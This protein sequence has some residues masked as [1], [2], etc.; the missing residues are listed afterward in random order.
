MRTVIICSILW[1]LLSC[2]GNTVNTG[3]NPAK[4][5][6]SD[7]DLIIKT[8]G[9]YLEYYPGKKQLKISGEFDAAGNKHGIWRFY[10]QNG[11]ETSMTTYE[12]GLREGF[13]VV[14]HPNGTLFYDGEYH[15]DTMVGAWTFYDKNGKKN[16]EIDYGLPKK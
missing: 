16:K 10:N 11:I 3:K 2:G 9:S 13:S 12:H 15:A 5:D 4:E 1:S 6:K 7:E 14:K 8:K